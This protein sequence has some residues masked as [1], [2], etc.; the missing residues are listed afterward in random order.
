MPVGVKNPDRHQI[1][2]GG[3]AEPDLHPVS[4]SQMILQGINAS[5]L[6]W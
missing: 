4:N 2:N 6:N 5:S 1:N 3:Q